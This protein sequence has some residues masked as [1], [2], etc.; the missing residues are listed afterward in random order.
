MKPSTFT[1]LFL[2]FCGD[3]DVA[4]I[5][6]DAPSIR[7]HSAQNET[8]APK[9]PNVKKSKASSIG[10]LKTSTVKAPEPYSDKTTTPRPV[11]VP[12]SSVTTVSNA[13]STEQRRTSS[14][15]APEPYLEETTKS[16]PTDAPKFSLAVVPNA[17]TPS[18]YK[19]IPIKTTEPTTAPLIVQK[20][21]ST[22]AYTPPPPKYVSI[23]A[24]ESTTTPLIV[25][26]S[27]NTDAYSQISQK[28]LNY[29]QNQPY[30]GQC[31]ATASTTG[32]Q[33]R[34]PAENGYRGVREP[35]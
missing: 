4:A 31:C 25:Q 22:D 7:S 14:T 10:K 24:T 27:S 16:R 20:S 29:N 2:C 19:R 26:A 23:K 21:S 34:N 30:P 35:L 8:K 3:F 17:T 11:D 1:S 6:L 32:V 18:A 13:S 9:S 12:K 28:P 15:K 5:L 33:C